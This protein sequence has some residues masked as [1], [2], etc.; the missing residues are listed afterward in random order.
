MGNRDS[1]CCHKKNNIDKDFEDFDARISG[2]KSSNSNN[3]NKE[4]D[5][6]KDNSNNSKKSSNINALNSNQNSPDEN[7]QKEISPERNLIKIQ[8]LIRKHLFKKKIN[9]LLPFSSDLIPGI[10]IK[11]N[12]EDYKIKFDNKNP[13]FIQMLNNLKPMEFNEKILLYYEIE[14]K[15]LKKFSILFPDNSFYEGQFNKN[16]KKEGL[17][18]L[19]LPNA[20]T[21][22]E[23][24]FKDGEMYGKGRLLSNEG[25]FYEGEFVKN[26]A[27]GYGKYWNIDGTN[28]IGQWRNDLQNGQGEETFMDNS[29]YIGNYLNGKKNGEGKFIWPGSAY[30]KGQFKENEICGEGI[31]YWKDGRIFSGNWEKNKM[32]GLGFFIWPDGKNYIGSY[33]DDKKQGYGLFTW[34]DGRSYEGE[35][36]N[37]KQHGFGLFKSKNSVRYGEWNNGDKICWYDKISDRGNYEYLEEQ[38]LSKKNEFEFNKIMKKFEME[39]NRFTA[40]EINE[41]VKIINSEGCLYKEYDFS[42]SYFDRNNRKLGD[43]NVNNINNND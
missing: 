43:N 23:G 35:W 38:I 14:D 1:L 34:P 7:Y 5:L 31:Y 15:F 29:K 22:Y 41:I 13:K 36:H 11:E 42:S 18:I 33:R 4:N 37:G 12:K 21:K 30:Y 24:V 32:E 9:K 10:I 40:G 28:Y 39:R 26:K 2:S 3:Q 6:Y 17:G 8:A 20:G 27:S 16:W 25:F 19:Y